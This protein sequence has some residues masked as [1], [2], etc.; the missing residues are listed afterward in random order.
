MSPEEYQELGKRYYKLEQYEKAVEAFTNGLEL[1]ANPAIARSLYNYRAASFDKLQ[2]F[3]YALKD[4]RELIRLNKK[5]AEGYLRIGSVLQKQ[6][7]LDTAI[8]IYKNGMKNVPV[9]DKGFQYLQQLHDKLTRMLSPATAVDPFAVLPVELVEMIIG[10][11]NFRSMVNCL[12]VCKGWKN[13][14]VK[15]PKLWTVLDLS[16]ARRDVSRNFVK[17]AVQYSESNI[18]RAIFHRFG[19]VH[20]IRN[21]ATACKS[22]T[23][24]EI[25]SGGLMADTLIEVAQCSLSLKKMVLRTD[26]SIDTI[27][28]IIRF[29]PSLEHLECTSIVSRGQGQLTTAQGPRWKGGPFRN[30]QTLVLISKPGFSFEQRTPYQYILGLIDD[31][32][33]LQ[34]LSLKN[35]ETQ[36]HISFTELPLISLVAQD[37]DLRTFPRLPNTLQQL[38]LNP[39]Y[40]LTLPTSPHQTAVA[41]GHISWHNAEQSYLPALTHLSFFDFQGLN[42]AFLSA[43]LD[44]WVN[45]SGEAQ[46]ISLNTSGI[47]CLQHLSIR[48]CGFE[49]PSSRFFGSAGLLSSSSRILTRSLQSMYVAF[50][51]LYQLIMLNLL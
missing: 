11:L 21:I 38:T 40:T 42:I 25:L 32:P 29:R 34:I 15:R 13:Y 14:L 6:N 19:H 36:H 20:I 4:G 8:A 12:R 2:N 31:S 46:R 17:N 49:L 3:N 24:V 47:S 28:Q 27:T 16:Q 37:F 45:D 26:I 7:K 48:E 30:L 18:S 5:D 1:A 50:P 41:N 51:Q 44:T 39:H 10:Y 43:L 33:R 9:N 22:L 35:F 23:H